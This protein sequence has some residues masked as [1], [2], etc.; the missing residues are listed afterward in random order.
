MA[1]GHSGFNVIHSSLPI[2]VAVAPIMGAA[3]VYWASKR[4]ER[5]RDAAAVLASAVTAALALILFGI[6]LHTPVEAEIAG[7]MGRGLTFRVDAFGGMMAALSSIVWFL[8]TLFSLKYMGHE[9]ARD[10]YYFFLTLT[11]SGCVGT[12]VAGDF[13]TLF[14]F[15]ELMTVASYVLVV[16]AETDEAVSAGNLY[17]YMGIF[18]GLAL[19]TGVFLLQH[20]TGSVAIRALL[21]GIEAKGSH[22]LIGFLLIVGFGVKAGMVPL[23]IWLPKAHPVAPSPA[24]ALLSG[25][26]IKAGAYGIIRTVTLVMTPERGHLWHITESYGYAIVWIGIITMFLAAFMALFQTNAKRILAY[27]SVSQ[28][29]YILMG[30]GSAAYLGIEGAMGFGGAS[31]H[32]MNHAFFK[33]AMFMLVGAI[34]IRTHT[35][36][37]REM[38]GLG[39][40]LPFFTVCFAV[41]AAGIMGIPGFGGYVSKTLLHHAVVEAYEHHHDS[42]LF[43]AEKLFMLTSSLTVCYISKL[44]YGLFL[45]EGMPRHHLERETILEKVVFG[46]FALAVLLLGQLSRP[47][48]AG[49]VVPMSEGFPYDHHVVEHLGHISVWS[50]HDLQGALTAIVL[51]IVLFAVFK[52]RRIFDFRLPSALSVES[53]LY[54]PMIGASLGAFVKAGCLVD[55]S[56]ENLLYRPVIGVALGAFVQTGYLLDRA[57]DGAYVGGARVLW[58]CCLAVGHFDGETLTQ[59]GRFFT[60]VAR[61]SRDLLQAA[62]SRN[63]AA[64]WKEGNLLT[65]KASTTMAKTDLDPEGDRSYAEVS[66]LNTDFCGLVILLFLA[67][68]LISGLISLAQR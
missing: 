63:V 67:I 37:I 22:G 38:G 26:M 16:H 57:V 31:Y 34:Y 53:I 46:G 48:L 7:V 45:G 50:W 21:E 17:M 35:L 9:H 30:V 51:G 61:G 60:R 44:F 41:A 40:D 65:S 33:G 56:V 28:M 11:L 1:A 47:V 18:G 12:F 6:A 13:F 3:L 36:D 24:S 2:W 58:K 25:I 10:R 62:V 68:F 52:S 54:R 64:I 49:I 59:V 4:S 27:S 55:Y 32:I 14:V 42:S 8:A 66:I 5:L 19:L 23:H 39:R 29:G 20:S 15:F 43:I